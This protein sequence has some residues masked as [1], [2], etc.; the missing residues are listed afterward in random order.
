MLVALWLSV[1]GS[2]Y[3]VILSYV[4]IDSQS[5]LIVTASELVR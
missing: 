3:N 4:R 5:N 1:I 2:Y